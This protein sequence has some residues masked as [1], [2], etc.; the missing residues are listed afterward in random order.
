MRSHYFKINSPQCGFCDVCEIFFSSASACTKSTCNDVHLFF[1]AVKECLRW[2]GCF[3][4]TGGT[5]CILS[6]TIFLFEIVETCWYTMRHPQL[7][8]VYQTTLIY[9]NIVRTVQ[10]LKQKRVNT[11]LR[12]LKTFCHFWARINVFRV[13]VLLRGVWKVRLVARMGW[14]LYVSTVLVACECFGSAGLARNRKYRGVVMFTCAT[15]F[16]F[17][18]S[19]ALTLSITTYGKR[20]SD[21]SWSNL[22]GTERRTLE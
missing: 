17:R 10:N 11:K 21:F 4:L 13:W 2:W 18:V 6:R 7:T 20:W 1:L 14:V 3:R 9:D 12:F 15:S 16:S 19:W 8:E 22:A 5:G